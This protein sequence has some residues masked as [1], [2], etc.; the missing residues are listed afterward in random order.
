MGRSLSGDELQRR[1][2]RKI[3]ER[4]VLDGDLF[5]RWLA[6]KG[7][8]LRALE[9]GEY[10]GWTLDLAQLL[11]VC[12]DPVLWCQAFLDDPKASPGTP[13]TFFEYQKSSV[14]AWNQDV[15][16]QDGAEVGKTR[17]IVA[18]LL[19]C[20][21]TAR[22]F[23]VR[24]PSVLVAAPQKTHLD[25]IIMEMEHHLGVEEGFDGR[26]PLIQHF[27]L[28]PVKTPHYLAKF[29]TPMGAG[30]V[31]FRPAGHDGESF[32]GVHVNAMAKFDEAAK[33]KNPVI[34]SEFVRAIMPGCYQ[35]V[36]SVPDGDNSSRYHQM[37]RE[38]IPGLKPGQ[39]GFRLFHWPKTLMPEPFWSDD[40]KRDMI[41]RYG[42]ES[43]PGYQR[44]VLGLHG[45]QENP[46]WAW[47][48]L[49][50]NIR[51][52]PEFRA[53][54]LAGNAEE[55]EMHVQAWRIDLDVNEGKKVPRV[56]YLA[57]RHDDLGNF[58]VKDR[59]LIR[60]RVRKLLR[61]FIE[62]LGQGVY[63]CGADLG[64]SRDP[65]EIAVWREIGT[66]LRKVVRIKATGVTYDLQCELIYC[67]DE[68]FGFQ[69]N[70]G[71]D[72]GNA[73]STVVQNLHNLEDYAAGDYETR[74]TGF[75]FAAA[76]D[77]VGESGDVLEQ[78]DKHGEPKPIRL[79][80]KE[81]ATNLLTERFQRAE[82][83]MP[84][85]EEPVANYSNHTAREGAKHRIFDKHDDH[86]IDADRQM[87]LRKVF[88]ET[89]AT[90]DNF[91]GGVQVRPAA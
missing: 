26:K 29:R 54:S 48:D 3:L 89:I 84:Y 30:R 2:H 69:P 51:D 61:E 5:E 56:T 47:S 66:E 44:N 64:F 28:K 34:W 16:H 42:G 87:M 70:W 73:G 77:A 35:R 59:E 78:E 15:V 91:A 31:Y 27:W 37:T 74:L 55:Q 82:M 52:V 46:V 17:E 68:I 50:P 81:H 45:Q 79:P 9:A 33:A 25:E 80:A 65:T 49:E 67:L 39:K 83:A 86:T 10:E 38:A 18:L 58:R 22:A 24:Q 62:P 72:F 13:Y 7:K 53:V 32:R 20:M 85:D 90:V 40:R 12:E 14:R 4:C 76:V 19:W 1:Q 6:R 63:W 8:G 11:C 43:T 21:C 88:N 41:R 60:A 36:Y 23:T 71:V 57:D 75:Q